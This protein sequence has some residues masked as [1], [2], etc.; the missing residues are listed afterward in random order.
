MSAKFNITARIA[1]LERTIARLP[2]GSPTLTLAKRLLAALK[3]EQQQE[4]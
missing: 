2:A 1:E 4:E 3:R